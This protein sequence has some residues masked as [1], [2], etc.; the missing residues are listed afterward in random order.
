MP[1]VPT[2]T[3]LESRIKKFKPHYIYAL[4]SRYKFRSENLSMPVHHILQRRA[5]SVL[6]HGAKSHDLRCV[7][8]PSTPRCWG[9]PTSQI[10]ICYNTVLTPIVFTIDATGA[11][12]TTLSRVSR[13]TQCRTNPTNT[14]WMSSAPR[15]ATA[16]MKWL[17]TSK[18][19]G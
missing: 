7:L 9:K 14:R 3:R 17:S 2:K 5:V 11:S 18:P 8:H 15:T 12:T 1:K 10:Q 4:R 16:W 6:Q 13:S 19:C